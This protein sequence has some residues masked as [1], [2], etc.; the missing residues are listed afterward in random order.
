[1]NYIDQ[2]SKMNDEFDNL[3]VQFESEYS[4]EKIVDVVKKIPVEL[5]EKSINQYQIII[6]KN[7]WY[8]PSLCDVA[9]LHQF[10]ERWSEVHKEYFF[11][12]Y[13]VAALMQVHKE[14][15]S[16]ARQVFE[17]FSKNNCSL[18]CLTTKEI[19]DEAIRSETMRGWV[20]KRSPSGLDAL[21]RQREEIFTSSNINLSMDEV[22]NILDYWGLYH[23]SEHLSAEHELIQLMTSE[24]YQE[25]R[26][27]V[28]R[29][30]CQYNLDNLLEKEEAIKECR[31][32]VSEDNFAEE[33]PIQG[34]EI[35]EEI[36]ALNYLN[37]SLEVKYSFKGFAGL[38]HMLVFYACKL[39]TGTENVYEMLNK[40]N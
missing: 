36:R 5:R 23:D 31:N 19:L 20:G 9:D 29:N 28:L 14:Y 6:R 2:L 11:P 27:E 4:I 7:K 13:L 35:L 37:L 8:Y 26:N 18:D 12:E 40:L 38:M 16:F 17:E 25:K 24:D 10:M 21:L 39:K 15:F 34:A 3:M 1:M 32:V 30:F 33:Q 22:D